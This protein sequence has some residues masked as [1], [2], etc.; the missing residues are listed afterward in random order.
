MPD[1]RFVLATLAALALAAPTLTAADIPRTPD[2]LAI[3]LAGGKQVTLSQYKGK[4][5]A[6]LFILTTC[7]HCEAAVQCL[8]QDQK[9]FG[10]RG[11][12]AIASAIEEQAETSVP[13]FI[14]RLK[15]PFP[16]GYSGLKPSMDFMQHPPKETPH[17]PLIAFIDRRG[18]LRAQYEGMEPFFV[19]DRMARNI[20]DKIAALLGAG[21]P[22]KAQPKK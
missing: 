10:P 19:P 13:E 2:E 1:R 20:H 4:V 21:A 15:P 14:R 11:F 7:P 5:V 3:T 17:M 22:A 9:E 8:M 18:I 16:V 12:Q 6:V